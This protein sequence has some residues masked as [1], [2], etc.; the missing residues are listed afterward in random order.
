MLTESALPANSLLLN[1]LVKENFEAD[2]AQLEQLLS[3]LRS[4]C[5]QLR[6]DTEQLV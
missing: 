3:L 4:N 6:Q 5:E 2:T 1:E